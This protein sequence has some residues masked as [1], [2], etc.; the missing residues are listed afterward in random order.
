M[1]Y[2]QFLEFYRQFTKA[3]WQRRRKNLS[4][5]WLLIFP[6]TAF[7]ALQ[8]PSAHPVVTLKSGVTA[9]E[10]QQRA[11]QFAGRR[12]RGGF[13]AGKNH[14][15]TSRSFW[16]GTIRHC[17]A[18]AARQFYGWR[19]MR[20]VRRSSWASRSIIPDSVKHL[21]V[22]G[23]FIDGNRTHQQRELWQLQGEGSEIRNNGITVQNVSDSIVEDV[24]CAHCR[25]GGLVTTLDMR[26]LT[27]HD[28]IRS[29]TI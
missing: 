8:T 24:T 7:A 12:R 13:A 1:I 5:A 15:S 9:V 29:T 16:S 3:C 26:R 18:R 22:S 14:D 19:I 4:F 27:V 25:S 6:A 21:C 28:L 23:I 2:R 20:I 10:I 11:G 17:A